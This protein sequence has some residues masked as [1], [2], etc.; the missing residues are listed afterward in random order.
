[1]PLPPLSRES[2]GSA[3]A[4]RLK[5]A[6][7]TVVNFNFTSHLPLGR[8][9]GAL[10]MKKRV[11]RHA[12][13]NGFVQHDAVAEHQLQ[14]N[15]PTGIPPAH[16]DLKRHRLMDANV[17]YVHV[18]S[19][20]RTFL[21]ISRALIGIGAWTAPDFTTRLFGIDPRRSDR[22]VA[23]LF[24]ARELALAGS[25]LAAPPAAL[26][27]V[28]MIGAIVDT[29]DSVGGFAEVKR[30]NLSTQATI[31][32]PIGAIGFAALGFIVARQAS[33]ATPTE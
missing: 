8:G 4:V 2:G 18:M 6:S 28:A 1:M 24:G 19:P 30:G 23:R 27:Q 12:V 26:P 22:F 11:F 10:R 20:A 21:G 25:L 15:Q 31:L 13:F 5:L 7:Y 14:T 17:V 32:G 3:G 9:A 33:A 16:Q 29:V